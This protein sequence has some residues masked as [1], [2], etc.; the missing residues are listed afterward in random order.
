MKDLLRVLSLAPRKYVTSYA[1]L[2][3]ARSLMSVLDVVGIAMIGLVALIAASAGMGLT[4]LTF[5]GITLP[6][7]N[8]GNL[9]VVVAIIFALF[10]AKASISTAI[11]FAIGNVIAKIDMNFSESVAKYVFLGPGLRTKSMTHSDIHWSIGESSSQASSLLLLSVATIV[12]DGFGLILIAVLFFIVDPMASVLVLGYFGVIAALLQL[13]TTRSQ[14]NASE[15]AALST[16]LATTYIEDTINAYRELFVSGKRR[17]FVKRIA[18]ARGDMALGRTR[19]YFLGSLPKYV[20]ETALMLGVLA[21]VCWQFLTD[22]PAAGFATIGVF[23]AGGLRIMGSVIPIQ[24]SMNLFKNAAIQGEIGLSLVERAKADPVAETAAVDETRNEIYPLHVELKGVSFKYP[25]SLT[26][27]LSDITLDIPA[28]ANY[29]IIGPSGSGK[30]TLVDL[31]LGVLT[32]GKG[33]ISIDGQEPVNYYGIS[34]N[35]VAYVPQKPGIISGTIAQNIALDFS[36]SSSMEKRILEAL[37]DAHLL[38]FVDTLPLGIHTHIGQ[39]H[40][41]LSGGQTQRLGIARA[42]YSKPGLLVLDEA[43]SALDAES[44]A[45]IGQTLKE[46]AGKVT[47]VVIAHRISTIQGADS[48][49]LVEAGRILGSGKFQQLRRDFPLVEKYV[50]LM[51]IDE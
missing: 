14:R 16:R 49:Y 2:V 30:T 18:S 37:G 7:L 4:N 13:L 19:L 48:V 45:F 5:M 15:L 32:P 38:D 17:E 44:E 11:S 22:S 27:T 25:G 29:A 9:V 33:E 20:I 46:L 31:M 35:R 47:T 50:Q 6:A 3:I 28:G 12:A 10:L 36:I 40:T 39:G 23:L 26:Q 34:S 24:N 1:L 41:E 21:F 42:L 51:S 43:T 8:Q